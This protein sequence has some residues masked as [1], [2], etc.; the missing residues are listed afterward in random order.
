MHALVL[1]KTKT[2]S[3]MGSRKIDVRPLITD[4]YAFADSIAAFDYAT[5][6]RPASVKVQIALT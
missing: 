5:A 4:T 2:L 3:L 6:I 1:E